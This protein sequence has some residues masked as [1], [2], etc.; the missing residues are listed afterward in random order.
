MAGYLVDSRIQGL[1]KDG[2]RYSLVF[3]V[4]D[5]QGSVNLSETQILALTKKFS[6]APV[7]EGISLHASANN[8]LKNKKITLTVTN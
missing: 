6:G 4:G 5:D 1:V 3:K 8:V 7:K 2:K